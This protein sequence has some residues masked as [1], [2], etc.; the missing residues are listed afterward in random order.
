MERFT[1]E[2]LDLIELFS[3]GKVSTEKLK[4]EGIFELNYEDLIKMLDTSIKND[5]SYSFRIIFN[6]APKKIS[7]QEKKELNIEYLFK[8]GHEEY[9]DIIRD[10]QLVY[11][12]EKEN[13][14]ILLKALKNIPEDLQDEDFKFPY[15]KK[16]I[17]AI[18]AQ[19]QPESLLALEKLAQETDDEK[20][21]ELA[22]HQLEKRKRLGRW[23]VEKNN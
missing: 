12:N 10:F 16:I 8:N 2:Q 3:M 18:G 22:L 1:K 20:I 17:Y 14:Y 21:K 19:P 23:E 5:D 13:I 4:E 11:N 9:E 7:F 15:I 6:Y